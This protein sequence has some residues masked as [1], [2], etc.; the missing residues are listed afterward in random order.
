M[1][2]YSFAEVADLIGKTENWVKRNAHRLPHHRFGQ[3]Y[4][5]LDDDV[6]EILA[7]ARVRSSG[8]DD[9]RPIPARRSA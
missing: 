8:D 4:S 1:K 5:F 3:T 9:M 6:T 7:A 2:R